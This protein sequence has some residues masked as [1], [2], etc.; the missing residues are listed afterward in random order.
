LEKGKSPSPD[1]MQQ[2]NDMQ[3]CSERLHILPAKSGGSTRGAPHRT[4]PHSVPGSVVSP[5]EEPR[6]G[7]VPSNV[8]LSPRRPTLYMTSCVV[9]L[10][11]LKH[12]PSNVHSGEASTE[13]VFADFALFVWVSEFSPTH[14]LFGNGR[15]LRINGQTRRAMMREVRVRKDWAWVPQR[16]IGRSGMVKKCQLFI[17]VSISLTLGCR[18]KTSNFVNMAHWHTMYPNEMMR[19]KIP[20]NSFRWFMGTRQSREVF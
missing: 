16:R 20:R 11:A 4:L 2:N 15:E 13:V 10:G 12:Q 6:S 5:A 1:E 18:S 3:I 7:T 8:T 14:S 9:T 19:P 17:M